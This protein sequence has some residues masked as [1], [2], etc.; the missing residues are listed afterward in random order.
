M[1]VFANSPSTLSVTSWTERLYVVLLLLFGIVI[2]TGSRVSFL[3]RRRRLSCDYYCISM[4]DAATASRSYRL[5]RMCTDFS[6]MMRL[7]SGLQPGRCRVSWLA[8][9]CTSKKR[10]CK[11]DVGCGWPLRMFLLWSTTTTDWWRREKWKNRYDDENSD[12][13]SG[14]LPSLVAVLVCLSAM[15]VSP[16]LS[17]PSYPFSVSR[18]VG[19][20]CFSSSP[21]CGRPVVDRYS[22]I[23]HCCICSAARW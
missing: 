6:R 23:M 2:S 14:V 11:H 8:L 1:F 13:P 10:T 12:Q 17:A 3:S 18:P 16:T 15:L 9:L 21:P 20:C 19:V 4:T 22:D 7:E 5:Y